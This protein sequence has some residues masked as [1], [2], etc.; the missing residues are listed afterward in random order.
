MSTAVKTT[1][2]TRYEKRFARPYSAFND[3][4]IVPAG[5]I[6]DVQNGKYWISPSNFKDDSILR[7]DAATHGFEVQHNEVVFRSTAGQENV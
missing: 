4:V 7:H 5:S 3:V 1:L 6:V 2:V